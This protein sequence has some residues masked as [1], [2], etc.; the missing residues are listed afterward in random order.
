MKKADFQVANEGSVWMF[1][2]MNKKAKK[3]V[4]ENVELEGWQW[5]GPRFAA[6]QRG[7]DFLANE[8]EG[9]GFSVEFV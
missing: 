4:S 6:D 5:L 8:L 1:Q 3:W 7:G 2:P 9:N